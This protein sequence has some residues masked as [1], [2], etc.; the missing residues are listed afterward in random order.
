MSIVIHGKQGIVLIQNT[1]K[2]LL[3]LI[4]IIHRKDMEHVEQEKR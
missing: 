2:S 1:E 3:L 4:I